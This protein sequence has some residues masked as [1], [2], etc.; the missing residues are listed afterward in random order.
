MLVVLL[1]FGGCGLLFGVVCRV[2]IVGVLFVY[3]VDFR[4]N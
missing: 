3:V 2:F 1:Y 4:Y